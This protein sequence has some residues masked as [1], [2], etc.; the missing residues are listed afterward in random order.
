[1]G[2]TVYVCVSV[3]VYVRACVCVFVQRYYHFATC[4]VMCSNACVSREP[5]VVS[6]TW[7]DAASSRCAHG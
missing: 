3:C 7:N 1:M 5:E 6:V 2:V 4:V